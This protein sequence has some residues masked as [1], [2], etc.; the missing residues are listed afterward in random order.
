MYAKFKQN[1]AK[2]LRLSSE[3]VNAS[4]R[5]PYIILANFLGP[6]KTL[7]VGCFLFVP[8]VRYAPPVT[9]HVPLHSKP[10]C[11]N[12]ARSSDGCK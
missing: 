9:E 12:M 2:K 11:K 8:S 6:G 10:L 4:C 1:Y 5:L 7:F 3:L